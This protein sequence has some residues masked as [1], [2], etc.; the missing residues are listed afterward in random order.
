MKTDHLIAEMREARASLTPEHRL[1]LIEYGVPVDLIGRYSLIGAARIRVSAGLY[2]PVE[3]GVHAYITPVF[4]DNPLT[5]E[6][7][8]PQ[9]CARGGGYLVDLVA[10]HPKYPSRWALRV[11]S[12][13]WLGSVE[14]QYFD[15]EPVAVRRSPLSWL[16]ANC[17]G[18]AILSQEPADAYKLLCSLHTIV[19]ED[20]SHVAELRKLVR[21]PWP[22]PSICAAISEA[23]DAA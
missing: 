5:P 13:V 18:L 1:E 8:G 23:R 19:A 2:D 15:P 4:V 6:A 12:A 21:R 20:G 22:L 3:D 14:P 10:W 9:G 16:Q 7:E 17:D 11:G